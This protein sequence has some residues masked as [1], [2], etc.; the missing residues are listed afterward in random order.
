MRGGAC[1]PHRLQS[2]SHCIGVITTQHYVFCRW[3]RE[4][5]LRRR[6]AALSPGAPQFF[7][8]ADLLSPKLCEVGTDVVGGAQD[9]LCGHMDL[10]GQVR[11]VSGALCIP[12][13]TCSAT[14]QPCGSTLWLILVAGSFTEA[15]QGEVC[16]ATC[17]DALVLRRSNLAFSALPFKKYLG[18]NNAE[19]GLG[20]VSGLSF[21]A[22]LRLEHCH[23][24]CWSCPAHLWQRTGAVRGQYRLGGCA[25]C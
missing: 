11:A 21:R 7:L 6:L 16:S 10:P 8:L 1:Y 15:V 12:P 17:P 4:R 25:N 13:H 14:A 3:T 18:L 19:Y 24:S 2:V 23:S 9:V 20:A 5:S 22:P